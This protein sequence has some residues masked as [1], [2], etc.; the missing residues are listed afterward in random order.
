[1][2]LQGIPSSPVACLVSGF[3]AGM[4]LR[5]GRFDNSADHGLTP[6]TSALTLAEKTELRPMQWEGIGSE[7]EMLGR[8]RIWRG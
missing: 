6:F 7:E 2:K 3:V 5:R 4:G 1:M 8:G